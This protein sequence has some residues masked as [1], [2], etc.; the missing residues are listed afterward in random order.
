MSS[1]REPAIVG[2]LVALLETA[3]TFIE[4]VGTLLEK[5]GALLENVAMF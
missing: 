3:G 5:T 4:I 1:P 2:L